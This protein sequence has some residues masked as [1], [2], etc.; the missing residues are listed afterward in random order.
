MYV[1]PSLLPITTFTLF[2]P[3]VRIFSFFLSLQIHTPR[4]L[5][6]LFFLL[7][8]VSLPFLSPY[9][10]SRFPLKLRLLSLFSLFSL[11]SLFP[12]SH[13]MALG[14]SRNRV[15][16]R[17]R[18][19]RSVDAQPTNSA[20]LST[21]FTTFFRLFPPLVFPLFLPLS[22]KHLIPGQEARNKGK[23]GGRVRSCVLFPSFLQCMKYNT[24]PCIHYYS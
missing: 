14:S 15:G 12:L 21:P 6:P 18:N 16:K 13:R 3:G 17:P 19:T 7:Y 1:Y 5:F 11:H 20:R 2:L 24:T 10:P 9:L 23:V 4:I 22:A 8:F